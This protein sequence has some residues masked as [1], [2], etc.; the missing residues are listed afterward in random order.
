MPKR[1]YWEDSAA[2]DR[3]L[4]EGRVVYAQVRTG[5]EHQGGIV[6]IEPQSGRHFWGRTL[7]E[8]DRLAYEACPDQWLYFCRLDD[9]TAE[10]VL[11]TW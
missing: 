11:P 8:A 3:L 7:G 9:P 10:I 5:L 2:K 4:A 6:A 1:A